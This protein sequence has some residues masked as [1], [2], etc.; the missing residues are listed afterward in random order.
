MA[1]VYGPQTGTIN[2][3]CT[4][5]LDPNSTGYGDGIQMVLPAGLQILSVPQFTTGNSVTIIPRIV[6]N[7]INLGNVNHERTQT[8][9]F[10]GGETW[11]I[12]VKGTIPISTDWTV[13]DDS[14]DGGPID[15][16]GTTL[17]NTIGF[18]SR[19]AKYWNVKDSTTGQ[20]KLVKQ[21]IINGVDI[22]PLRDDIPTK[23]GLDA[24]PIVD[25]LQISVSIGYAAPINYFSIKLAP[26]TSPT[27]LTHSSSTS[28]LDIQNYT[29]F[30]GT[31]DS[32]AND[33][34]GWG[35]TDINELQKDYI[36]KFTGVWD[37]LTTGTGQVVHFIK[38]GTGSLATI[39]KATSLAT[40]PLNPNPGTNAPFLIRIP[41]EVWSKDDNR[42]VNLMFR[43][44]IQNE[45]DSPFWAWNPVNRMYAIVVDSPYDTVHAIPGKVDPLNAL[46]TWVLVFYGTNYTLGDQ[47]TITYANP[48]Q[49][50][51]DTYTFTPAA[52]TFSTAQ[53]KNDVQRIN[54][55][56]N[57]YYAVNSEELNKYNRFVT[58]NHLPA[59]ATIHIF[60]LA[61]VL[62]KTIV[63]N[64]PGQFA[65][66]DLNN[67]SNLPVASG[68]Y[69]AYIDMPSLGTTN[70]LKIAIIQE[71]QI[72][73]RF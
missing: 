5:N 60:N 67:Q 6:G 56:P 36:L 16:S 40:H 24:N 17:V 65:R 46:A 13:F 49:I 54:V 63:K 37:S 33:N 23:V 72:L 8:A 19:E 59:S 21:S 38:P 62:I 18:I 47:V 39:F 61:G 11:S 43:D 70:I 25:G 27:S 20:I 1:A 50:G 3:N 28:T 55:F 42:Q 35:T 44:R 15:V 31:V 58:F 45:T 57:P 22:F 68:L 30:G 64:D 73:D 26:A 41:F 52:S 4:F 9:P 7:T 69:I 53:A 29:I 10:V 48:V 12:L 14:T 71:Q 51:K 66:W 32:Y 34:F 2:L